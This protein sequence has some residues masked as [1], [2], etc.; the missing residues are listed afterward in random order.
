MS[1]GVRV[2]G[3]HSETEPGRL[4][5]VVDSKV[6]PDANPLRVGVVLSFLLRSSLTFLTPILQ[7][8]VFGSV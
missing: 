3:T 7:H 6:L 2:E 1:K 8:M 4:I 5:M